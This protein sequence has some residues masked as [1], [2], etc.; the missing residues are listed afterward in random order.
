MRKP[1][2]PEIKLA[3]WMVD[4]VL[5]WLLST[6]PHHTYRRAALHHVLTGQLK[7]APN[8]S[9]LVVAVSWIKSSSPQLRRTKTMPL[10]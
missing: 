8:C 2:F 6:G 5:A 3:W 1:R 7:A 9:T 4:S 10:S